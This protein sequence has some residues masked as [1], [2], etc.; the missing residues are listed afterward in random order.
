MPA[1]AG[2]R[3]SGNAPRPTRA[4]R[5]RDSDTPRPTR[6]YSREERPL[7]RMQPR[8]QGVGG[9]VL[10][11]TGLG[12]GELE[13]LDQGEPGLGRFQRGLAMDRGR[14][15]GPDLRG[16]VCNSDPAAEGRA[17]RSSG[18]PRLPAGSTKWPRTGLWGGPGESWGR[19]NVAG[20]VA[21]ESQSGQEVMAA[22]VENSGVGS[23]RSSGR[24][25]RGL[26]EFET[27]LRRS[28]GGVYMDEA[29][30]E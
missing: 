8:P 15:D 28:R 24:G 17:G 6:A 18:P 2:T 27:K 16:G 11:G 29:A 10:N 22:P 25:G 23:G 9:G 13:L 20:L 7:G 14:T 12:F 19:G 4:G 21:G 30:P 26:G 5:A 1:P 3:T